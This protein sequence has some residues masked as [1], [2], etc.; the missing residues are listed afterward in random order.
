MDAEFFERMEKKGQE[1]F[2][3]MVRSGNLVRPGIVKK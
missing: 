1:S 3:E 2:D